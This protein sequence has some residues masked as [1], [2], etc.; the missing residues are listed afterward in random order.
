[1]TSIEKLTRLHTLYLQQK[2]AVNLEVD[3]MQL[4]EV[5]TLFREYQTKY[6]CISIED[7]KIQ[8]AKMRATELFNKE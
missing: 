1:M 2:S 3:A 4:K 8:I 5:T 7:M 6:G